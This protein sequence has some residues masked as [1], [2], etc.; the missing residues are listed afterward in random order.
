MRR[1]LAL[2]GVAACVLIDATLIGF[3]MNHAG[4]APGGSTV[5]VTRTVGASPPSAMAR[6]DTAGAQSESPPVPS[7]TTP[8]AG[9]APSTRA[10]TTTAASTTVA[11]TPEM[12]TSTAVASG[13][14]ASTPEGRMLLDMSSDGS[15]IR[16]APGDCRGSKPTPNELS[17][18]WGNSWKPASVDVRQV[19][20]VSARRDGNVWFVGAGADCTPAMHEAKDPAV[21]RP[22]GGDDGVWYLSTDAASTTVKAPGGPVDSGC[23]PIGPE[24]I[25]ARAAYLL[26][27]DGVLRATKDG[28]HSWADQIDGRWRGLHQLHRREVRVCPG[29]TV[30]VPRDRPGHRGRLS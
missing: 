2:I 5:V 15:V 24:P 25:D 30:R 14:G 23:V 12:G 20:R 8:P 3:A 9:T 19:L 21:S 17:A 4:A 22:S 7:S 26:S 11:K 16:A 27:A 18:D 28:G 6:S 29:A 10:P 1:N 13:N